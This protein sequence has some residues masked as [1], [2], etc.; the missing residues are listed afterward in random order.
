MVLCGV[1]FWW[2][3]VMCGTVTCRGMMVLY[4]AVRWW[5]DDIVWCCGV[6]WWCFFGGV[7]W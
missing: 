7:L 2:C 6:V 4:G 5:Y 1:L 3:G